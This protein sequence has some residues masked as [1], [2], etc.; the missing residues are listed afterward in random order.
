MNILIYG[1]SISTGTHGDGAYLDALAA[2]FN[3]TLINRAVGSSGTAL[4]TPSSMLSQLEKYDDR[5]ADIVIVW[6]GS[7]DWYWGTDME[8]FRSAVREAVDT[9]RKRNPYSPVIWF[10]PLSYRYECPDGCS[11]KG[12]AAETKNKA[13]YTI[14]DYTASLKEEAFRNNFLF[15]DISSLVQITRYNEKKYLEDGVH[16]SRAGYDIIQK[17]IIQSVERLLSIHKGEFHES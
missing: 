15:Q 9:I 17:A 16:P 5:N 12:E 2:A 13:G 8:T 10:S 6:H 14:L 4:T 1:D 3:A 7:N 11:I